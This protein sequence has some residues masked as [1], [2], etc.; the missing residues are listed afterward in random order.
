MELKDFVKTAISD[1][2]DAIAECQKELENGSYIAPTVGRSTQGKIETKEGNLFVSNIDFEVSVIASTNESSNGKTKKGIEVCGSVL[3][4]SIKG[5]IGSKSIGDS[6]TLSNENITKI[7][8]SIP[9]IYPS[10]KVKEK[11]SAVSL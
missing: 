1:I 7:R 8:F 9:V 11:L 6:S 3:G 5:G 10:V 4:I 2:T